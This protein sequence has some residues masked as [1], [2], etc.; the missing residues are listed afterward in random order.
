MSKLIIHQNKI[1]NIETVLEVCPF[2]AL[3]NINGKVTVNAA[4]KMCSL[5][6][7]KG[8]T[9]AF[10]IVE[11]DRPYIDK[12]LWEGIAVF[13]E[14]SEGKIHP[15]SYEL[16]GKARE[17]A[18][19]INHP[20]YCLLAGHNVN[21]YAD[22]ILEWGIDELYVYD[23]KEL[24]NFKIEPYKA[25]FSDFINKTKPSSVLVGA[26]N[27]G[28]SLAP[29]VAATFKT[30]LTADCT[31]LDVQPNTDLDQI[32]PAFGGNIMA[33]IRT[34][35]HRPQFATVRYKVFDPP[36]EKKKK[37]NAKIVCCKIDDKDL[38]SDIEIIEIKQKAK[39]ANIEDAPIIVA[40]GRAFKKKEDLD[41][42]NELAKLLDAELGSSR[43]L[44]EAGIVDP[45]RQ[46]GLS[47][48]TVKPKLIIT[49]GISGAIQFRAGMS[50]ADTI[51]A[52]NSDK[53]A[54][55]FDVA[56][57]GIVGDVYE[58]IPQL[59]EKIKSGKKLI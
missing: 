1:D 29:R 11:T 26:T 37:D 17:M 34:P 14:H 3:E 51:I 21:K 55:I 16:I 52:I 57:Y 45:I 49:C 36:K 22:K 7:K 27:I 13:I 58:I 28:R 47:G 10:E 46:I 59:I 54:P 19:K 5:C 6:V 35:D 12:S 20:V 31:V 40:V 56:H 4:C 48:R 42:V 43:P 9:D 24:E 39:T 44:I 25:V 15:V 38:K 33:H 41:T 53:N 2:N 8:P 30:G 50:N 32:R 18:A 23:Q